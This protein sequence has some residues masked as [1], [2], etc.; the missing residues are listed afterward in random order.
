MKERKGRSS[1]GKKV[2]MGTLTSLN[3]L[4]KEIKI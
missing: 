3:D 1:I 4:K 2:M